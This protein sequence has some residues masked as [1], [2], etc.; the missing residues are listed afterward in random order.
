MVTL[1]TVSIA[2]DKRSNQRGAGYTKTLNAMLGSLD[3][4]LT[5]VHGQWRP[6]RMIRFEI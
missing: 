4:I 2:S 5:R 1:G 6:L 3:F